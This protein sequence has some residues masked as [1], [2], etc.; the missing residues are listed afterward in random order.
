MRLK[1]GFLLGLAAIAACRA[2]EAL[3]Q[4]EAAS[5]DVDALQARVEAR[6]EPSPA[7]DQPGFAFAAVGPNNARIIIT[8]GAASIEHALP[9][10][11]DTVFHVASL[12]KQI[13][14]AML[15]HAILDGHVSL[16]DPVSQWIP[17]AQ[18]FGD[19]LTVAHLVYMTS[20][21]PEYYSL[22]RAS[23]RP[24]VTFHY[25]DIQEALET[26]LAE[27]SLEFEPGTRWAYSNI[28]YMLI[29]EIVARAY[30]R[31]FEALAHD[32]LFAPLGMDR[33]LIHAD[34]TTVAPGR[35]DAYAP[36]TQDRVDWLKAD[37]EIHAAEGEGWMLL[38]RNA[39]HYGGSGVLSSLS[40]W[41]VWQTEMH[42]RS[43]FGDAFWELMF[44]TRRFDHDKDNDAFGLVHSTYERRAMLWYAGGDIDTTTHAIYFPETGARLVCLSNA[45]AEDC[46][47]QI[48]AALPALQEAGWLGADPQPD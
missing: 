20:G 4:A 14:A 33:T 39:P 45:P 31:P 15:A 16:D 8:S 37:G 40:D 23:G 12:S 24:W 6:L 38:R 28:N 41:M 29:A 10:T 22:G 30:G 42:E 18:H 46:G 9:I 2:P 21:V 27:E 1:V 19:Q 47:D 35:A 44:S 26:S 48:Y 3:D 36:R 7:L 17:E 32:R 5:T 11:P 34:I 13:T 43:V 25:F